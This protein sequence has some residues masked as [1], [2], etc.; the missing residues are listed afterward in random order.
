MK[1]QTQAI[2]FK[3]D[4]KLIDRIHEKLGKMEW[5]FDRI[6][7]A[8]VHL[9]LENSGQVRDKIMEVQLH[10]PGSTL[11]ASATDK[12]FESALD[13]VTASLKKQL[14]RYKDRLRSN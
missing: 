7:N 1:I 8:N 2:Q 13:S 6:I 12:S 9:K 5:L 11:V 14:I 10:V 3:A 4:G